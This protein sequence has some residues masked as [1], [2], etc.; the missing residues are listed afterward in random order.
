[1]LYIYIKYKMN[2]AIASHL[3][4]LA[5]IDNHET[6]VLQALIT[7]LIIIANHRFYKPSMHVHE[8]ITIH[9]PCYSLW[10]SS[11]PSL[12]IKTTQLFVASN[13]PQDIRFWTTNN[14]LSCRINTHKMVGLKPT[15]YPIISQPLHF[16]EML[17]LTPHCISNKT[18]SKM[19]PQKYIPIKSQ[20]CAI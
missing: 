9:Q 10:R 6:R 1:M 15:I 5:T 7:I 13:P 8:L 4:I 14:P 18:S 17:A 20:S 11:I 19:L 12:S 2:I 3:F 16:H